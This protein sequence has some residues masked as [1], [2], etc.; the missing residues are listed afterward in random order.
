MKKRISIVLTLFIF[1]LFG[2]ILTGCNPEYSSL[3]LSLN[4]EQ[5]QMSITDEK[6]DYYITIENYFDFNAEFDFSFAKAVARIDAQAVEYKGQGVYKFT[7][8]PLIAEST[9]LTITLKGLDKPL[10]VPIVI[11]REVT[12]V[13]AHEGLFVV[14]GSSLKLNNSMFDFLPGDTNLKGLRFE[15]PIDYA[16]EY[17]SNGVYLSEE[18]VLSAPE[19]C[20][21]DSIWVTAISTY[22]ANV[23]TTFE[24]LAINNINTTNFKLKI[25][26]QNSLDPNVFDDYS[27]NVLQTIM[28]EDE[29]VLSL[30]GETPYV[31]D[32]VISD[33]SGFQKKLAVDYDLWSKGYETTVSADDNLLLG[34]NTGDIIAKKQNF[35]FVLSATDVGESK[36]SFKVYQ[37]NLT[38]N[39]VYVNLYVKASS[40]PRQIAINGQVSTGLVE[41]YTNSTEVKEFNFSVVPVKADKNKYKYMMSFYKGADIENGFIDDAHILSSTPTEY[42]SVYY[43]GAKL[44]VDSATKRVELDAGQL[45]KL[46]SSLALQAKQTTADD[47]IAIKLDCIEGEAIIASAV[48]YIKVYVGTTKFEINEIYEDGTIYLSLAHGK[49]IFKGLTVDAG[50]TAGKLTITSV[51]IGEAVCDIEQPSTANC[52]LEITPKQVGEQEFVITTANNLSVVLKVIVIQQVYENDFSISLKESE[53]EAVAN[54]TI[55]NE[56]N[57]L[58]TVVIKG[59]GSTIKL[60]GSINGISDV[61]KNSYSYT[62]YFTE[63]VGD[64]YFDIADNS[65]ITSLQFTKLYQ[66]AT[67]SY[68]EQPVP[69]YVDLVMYEVIDFIRVEQEVEE[70]RFTIMLQCVNYIKELSLYASEDAAGQTKEKTVSIYN[71]GDLSYVNQNLATVY[72]YMDLQQSTNEE[73]TNFGYNNFTFSSNSQFTIDNTTGEVKRGSEVIGVL[74]LNTSAS[75]NGYLGNFTYDYKG[76]LSISSIKIVFSITDA[77]TLI[78]F[79]SSISISVEKY[80]DVDSLWLSIPQSVIYLDETVSNQKT[81]ISVQVLPSNAMCSELDVLVETNFAGCIKVDNDPDTNILTFTYQSAGNGTIY[82]FPKSKMKTQ[83]YYDEFGNMYYHLALEFVCADGKTEQ[84]ALRISTYDDLKKISPDKHYYVDSSIDCK[85]SILDIPVFNATLR[86]TFEPE[87][88]SDGTKNE[89]FDS[90]EQ[91]GSITNFKV[92]ING[93]ANIGMFRTLSPTAK[94]Y[95]LSFIGMFDNIVEYDEETK[96]Y[97]YKGLELSQTSYIGLVCGTNYGTIKNVTANLT[98]SCETKIGNVSTNNIDVYVGLL[99]GANFAAD[100]NG[101]FVTDACKTYTLLANNT[102]N[103]ELKINFVKNTGT[104]TLT[105]Y[106]GGVV[107]INNGVISQ[108][109]KQDFVTIGLYGITSSVYANVNADFMAGVAGSNSGTINGLKATGTIKGD[110]GYVAGFVGKLLGGNITNNVSRVFVSG[111]NVVSGFVGQVSGTST[112]SDN[113][114]QATDD[115]TKIAKD[116][117]LIVGIGETSNVYAVSEYP[118][119]GVK[120]ETYFER[121]YP[122]DVTAKYNTTEITFELSDNIVLDLQLSK[123]YYYGDMLKLGGDAD[124]TL[125]YVNKFT[126]AEAN[127]FN[128]NYI[129]KLVLPAYKQAVFAEQQANINNTIDSL[130]LLKFVRIGSDGE[131]FNINDITI[132]LSNLYL[133]SLESFGKEI[134]LNGVGSLD[135]TVVSSLNY[136]KSATFNVYITNYYEDIKIYSSKNKVDEVGVIELLNAQTT[137]IYFDCYST[138]Y[139]YK[140]T[141]I[142]LASNS[143]VTFDYNYAVDSTNDA[144]IT[145]IYGQVGYLKTTGGATTFDG[146][147]VNF[148]SKFVYGT[149]TYYR[150]NIIDTYINAEGEEEY[151]NLVKY[152]SNDLYTFAF[153]ST[154]DLGVFGVTDI[155][156]TKLETTNKL[157]N[158]KKGVDSLKLNKYLVEAEPT[159]SIDIIATYTSYDNT[160]LGEV[161]VNNDT[162][163][164]TLNI[165]TD[166]QKNEYTTYALS[167]DGTFKGTSGAILDKT[168]FSLSTTSPVVKEIIYANGSTTDVIAVKY[169]QNYTLKM[170]IDT[171]FDIDVYNYLKDKQIELVLTPNIA[172]NQ[173]AKILV[174]YT[175]ESI[176]SVLINNYNKNNN[177]GMVVTKD[178]ITNVYADN[179]IYSGSQTSINEVN[180]LNAY[181]YTRLSEFDYVDVTLNLGVEGGYLAFI[182]YQNVEDKK[183]GYVS[184]NS[185]YTSITGGA[186]LRIYKEY[187]NV[188][189]YSNTLPISL[190]YKIP[191]TI[192]DGT[193]VPIEFKFYEND[194]IIF[195]NQINLLAKMENQVSFEIYD[196]EPINVNDD[197]L[198]YQVARGMRY[199]LDTTIIGYTEDQA[200]FESSSP[201][202]A[203]VTKEGGDYYLNITQKAINYDANEY[204]VVTINSYG[205]KLEYNK[206]TTSM[207]ESTEIRIYEYLV[208]SSNLFGEDTQIGLRMKQTV[209]I[210]EMIADKISF[211]YSKLMANMLNEFK[212]SYIDNASFSFIDERGVEYDLTYNPDL[213]NSKG[214]WFELES[215]GLYKIICFKDLI[216][217]ELHYNFTPL[218]IGHPCE[219]SFKVYHQIKYESGKPVVQEI[220]WNEDLTNVFEKTFNL[221]VYVA[222]S[223]NNATPIYTYADMLA[224]NDGEYYRLVNDVTIKASEFE[225]ISAT[226]AMFD[227][228]GYAIKITSGAISVN[229]D[230]SSAFALFKT[231]AEGSVFK[232]ITIKIDG[233]LTMTLNNTLNVSGAN[234]AILASENNG[235]I[236]NC[237]VKSESVV[238]A[239]IMSTVSVM[240]KSY[241]AGLCAINNGYITN[242]RIECNLTANGASLGGVVAENN[243]DIAST[244]IKNSRLYN[245]SSTT[246]ENIV[247]GGFV[248]KNSGTINMCYIEGN[249]NSSRIY[250]DYPTND[251]TLNSKI[252]YTATKVAGFVYENSGE[253]YDSYSNIPIVSTNMCSGFVGMENGGTITRVFSLC[254]LKSNDTLNYGF[255]I[256]YDQEK[257]IFKDCFFVIQNNLINFNTSESNYRAETVITSSGTVVV[258]SSKITGIEPLGVADFNIVE[259]VNGEYV[260]KQDTPFANFITDSTKE[261]GI[262]F[263]AFD[264]EKEKL[265][266]FDVLTYA[267]DVPGITD[268]KGKAQTFTARRL[269]LVSPNILSYSKYDLEFVGDYEYSEHTYLLSNDADALGSKT[270]PYVITSAVEFENFCNQLNENNYEYY[271]L[272]CD[273]DFAKEGIYT[274]NLFNKTLVGY[275]EGN[276]FDVKAYAVN[277]I[278]S[279]L[280][281]GLFAQIGKQSANFSCIKNVNFAPTYINLPNSI[282]VGGVAGSLVNAN[283]Y[284]IDILGEEVVIVG[285]NIVGGLFG[286]TYGETTLNQAYADITAKAA[287][288]NAIALKSGENINNII[289]AIGYLENGSNKT[290]VSYAGSIIG[291][292]GGVSEI[293]NVNIGIHARAQGMIAGLLFGGIGS[294]TTVTDFDLQ[295]DSHLN[296]IIAYAFAGLVA[297]ENRGNIVDFTINSNILG[298][299]TFICEPVTPLAI[300]GIAGIAVDG[301]VENMLS[302]QGYSVIAAEILNTDNNTLNPYNQFVVQYVGGI[303]GYAKGVD[304]Q[305]VEI[306]N[307]VKDEFTSEIIL[308]E[309]TKETNGLVVM[310][311]NYVGS[312]VGYLYETLVDET[313]S[314]NS[315]DSNNIYLF[316][317][318]ITNNKV[319]LISS[320]TYLNADE[321][322]VTHKTYFSY[323]NMAVGDSYQTIE[324]THRV[325]L[326][327][328]S[329]VSNETSHVGKLLNNGVDET[330]NKIYRSQVIDI[331]H[332]DYGPWNIK[333]NAI[334]L[335]TTSNANDDDEILKLLLGKNKQY[336]NNFYNHFG[337]NETIDGEHTNIYVKVV[338]LKTSKYVY[339]LWADWLNYE[340]IHKGF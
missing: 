333:Q 113:I 16:E 258:Y 296:Q 120:C 168:L 119:T 163:V 59:I 3:S 86:G 149:S 198:V 182:E 187:I 81:S 192:S 209:D 218:T 156:D 196:K 158:A 5:I 233:N 243:G 303:Y 340:E 206:L 241:F 69:L 53:S 301:K 199:L 262:W 42:I 22:D 310:G 150:Y 312:L 208:D 104:T 137:N 50:A 103:T 93:Y 186:T 183:I 238:A 95:N 246:N 291:Y 77:Y 194:Q 260:I 251:Y 136:K 54:S 58:S 29:L 1:I 338:D 17:E 205:Q 68:I 20:P 184:T 49:Q 330:G 276:G 51:N 200:V 135:I 89:K 19:D 336:Y 299:N 337:T 25:A 289:N 319:N 334:G 298:V 62:L 114:V 245:T 181:V 170:A 259:K 261:H 223:E 13:T 162:V 152:S 123:D 144:V 227:G 239:D 316:N 148:V 141:P 253:I 328:G 213:C 240:E 309:E 128:I 132:Q 256:S 211:E 234:I 252:I 267:C 34:G 97:N 210:R 96:T 277:S 284:N 322:E 38:R 143:E 214:V 84:T 306:G 106:F 127:S 125:V 75:A 12:G 47:Y 129:K 109:T 293:T 126:Q 195:T 74:T 189:D 41:L 304:I 67:N 15:F 314:V 28:I 236:T 242:S 275:F 44:E 221:N 142:A 230:N 151:K 247:S 308:Q 179:I 283:V 82:I 55:N 24:V 250:S 315:V 94:I 222:S 178:G 272:V 269:Q 100:T 228:N 237:A 165:Y 9:T 52:D 274:T 292:A 324:A 39:H 115:G 311:G 215:T 92:S 124:S 201:N 37:A 217:N 332:G 325:G 212:Q 190:I 63:G 263:Y 173:S 33:N 300:G 295:L 248:C 287:K 40:K 11:T 90:S 112:L 326:V 118:L 323:V 64:A 305:N 171:D 219:Y 105:S 264:E 133:A 220:A 185:V 327:Y 72:L 313:G 160:V 110:A 153:I 216:T 6:A 229:L 235:I 87:F 268:E 335:A 257:S 48:M 155:K 43:G 134:N 7:I 23:T 166:Y 339:D 197:V 232:N 83:S 35:D 225:M 80:I 307:Y 71:K 116:A 278:T 172:Q 2:T 226:P 117:S 164:P 101:I 321:Q 146:K 99:A 270:N 288:Y 254:K 98:T 271:R 66:A 76:T 169:S 175:P 280:S 111:T 297:G 21:Y 286:R 145:E 8:Y 191:K 161:Y 224:M 231:V 157:I 85:G 122:I 73:F 4:V 203:Y 294:I 130:S 265:N 65:V 204:F 177:V 61:D 45:E 32:L 10:T 102:V 139:N 26:S 138:N 285:R 159:D 255:V 131:I 249:A 282:Y 108:Q 174:Q 279:N 30:D 14:R 121:N 79:S 88:N 180:V 70:V 154:D 320:K 302:T 60:V 329:A 147:V 188:D 18:F 46:T 202:I 273:I 91:I 36:I 281:A 107:G 57:S 193:Y 167:N 27:N 176:T 78:P 318:I 266:S 244:Y 31:L 207:I 140:N 331:F 290:E 317:T 56:T